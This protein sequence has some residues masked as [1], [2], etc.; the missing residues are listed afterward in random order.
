MSLTQDIESLHRSYRFDWKFVSFSIQNE[1]TVLCIRDGGRLSGEDQLI[2]GLGKL[3]RYTINMYLVCSNTMCESTCN[4]GVCSLENWNSR[5][6]SMIPLACS[7][8]I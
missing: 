7:S 5:D 4:V 8:H 1:V 6:F 3:V 2:S